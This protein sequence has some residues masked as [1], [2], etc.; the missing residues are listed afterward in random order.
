MT[1]LREALTN[2]AA[3]P[4]V[5]ADLASLVEGEVASMGGFT[6]I[7]AKAALKTN[8]GLVTQMAGAY[9]GT[10][11]DAL[12]GLWDRFQASGEA[13]FGAFLV[14]NRPEAESAIMTAVEAAA[15]AGGQARSMYDRFKLQA[16][17]L[18]SGAL[19]K[20]GALVQKHAA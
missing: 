20:I 10:F 15:P 1:S 9:A 13:D 17:K 2:P 5:V 16:A 11:A 6:G 8:P 14:A 12:Q 7:G 4:A 3:K 18:L 19:P